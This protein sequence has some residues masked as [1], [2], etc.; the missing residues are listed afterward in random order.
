MRLFRAGVELSVL[1]MIAFAVATGQDL[2][3]WG[4]ELPTTTCSGGVQTVREEP[5]KTSNAVTV[6]T[7]QGEWLRRLNG[8]PPSREAMFRQADRLAE[9]SV[10]YVMA[11]KASARGQQPGAYVVAYQKKVTA[12]EEQKKAR[13]QAVSS[14]SPCDPGTGGGRIVPAAARSGSARDVA[15]RAA[16]AAGWRGRDLDMSIAVAEGESGFKADAKNPRSSALGVWQLIAANRVGIDGTNPYA[17]ARAA[18]DLWERRGWGQWEVYNTGAHRKFL[19]PVALPA[20]STLCAGGDSSGSSGGNSSVSKPKDWDSYN[21]GRIPDEALRA[22]AYVRGVKLRPDA[23]IAFD[24]LTLAYRAE[25]GRHISVTDSYRPYDVQAALR[26]EK[27]TL[28]ARAGRSNHGWGTALDLGGGI[29]R[30]GSR[31]HLW[32]RANAPEYGWT[33]PTWARAGGSKPEPWHWEFDSDDGKKAS[34]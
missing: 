2:G 8:P 3:W 9:A 27:P 4:E 11:L 15:I 29:Q 32:M 25:F 21:N 33:H 10:A 18:H 34:A 6:G 1:S 26:L 31:Q 23:A 13:I 14:C 16:Y 24:R 17:N 22:S 19:R 20:D 7:R 30:F 28:A 5:L 12:Q